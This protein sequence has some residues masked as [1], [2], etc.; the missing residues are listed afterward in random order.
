MVVGKGRKGRG[1]KPKV[2][3]GADPRT[4]TPQ[5]LMAQG[6][7]LKDL[8]KTNKK[9]LGLMAQPKKAVNALS[10]GGVLIRD[11]PA[12]FHSSVYPP[13]LE[14][15]AKQMPKGKDAYGRG[16]EAA[17]K[18][19]RTNARGAIVAEVMKK[20]GLSLAEASKYVK[21]KGLY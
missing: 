3:V 15:Y 19:K 6:A 17:P 9:A 13:A 5:H 8:V 20:H 18:P 1:R 11:D 21:E 16:R 7:G 4:Y 2:M 14:S 10:Q 12:Q